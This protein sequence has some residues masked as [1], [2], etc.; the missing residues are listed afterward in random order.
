MLGEEKTHVRKPVH[1]RGAE[2]G[3]E[4]QRITETLVIPLRSLSVLCASAVNRLSDMSFLE[5]TVIIV[6]IRFKRGYLLNFNVK[7]LKEGIKRVSI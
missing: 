1:R 3:E 6:N 4:A 7:L 2:N 5:R